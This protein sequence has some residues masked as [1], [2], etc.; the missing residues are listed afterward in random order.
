VTAGTRAAAVAALQTRLAQ[1]TAVQP[2]DTT[3]TP[4]SP[5]PAL[6]DYWLADI[7]LDCRIAPATRR[8]YEDSMRTV[9]LPALGGFTLREIGVA[10]CDALI[11][12]LA[13]TS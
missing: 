3:L 8:F 5:L 6:V 9:V 13:Q 1:R 10:R 7:D 2:V 4:D 12:Q 11:K